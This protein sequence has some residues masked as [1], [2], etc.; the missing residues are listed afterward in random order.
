MCHSHNDYWR[1]Q[2]FRTA[3]EAGCISIE[4]DVYYNEGN[5]FVGHT[6]EA[7]QLERTLETLYLNPLLDRLNHHNTGSLNRK[8]SSAQRN[9]IFLSDPH[10]S[11][12]LVIDMKKDSDLIW[13]VL[14]KQLEPLRSLNYLAHFDG[15][16]MVSGPVIVVT[17]GDASFYDIVRNSSYRDVFFDAP[18]DL[19]AT[20]A[21]S[22]DNVEDISEYL[23]DKAPVA[24]DSD[25]DYRTGLPVKY[26]LNAAVYSI[27]NSYYASTSFKHSVGYAWNSQLSTEQISL[28]RRH[29]RAAHSKG[30]R[31][32]YFGVPSWPLSMRN[33]L[34][35]VLIR[36]GVDV[37]SVDDIK[38]VTQLDFGPRKGGWNRK[39]WE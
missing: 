24:T 9:G 33:Y 18:L 35:R 4:A 27:S 10:Q 37:L 22:A 8:T 34:W 26:P 5:L 36:E 39:W 12:V 11:L 17:S 19:I 7:L 30:L 13:P 29:I 23:V 28:I 21:R 15:I 25:I 38:A 16:D 1:A 3:V 14:N 2:P 32:R 6:T 20:A 31:V